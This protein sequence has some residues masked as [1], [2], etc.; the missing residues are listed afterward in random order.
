MSKELARTADLEAVIA[1]GDLNSLTSEQRIMLYQRTCETLG[2]N[3][4]TRPLEYLKL[5]GRTVIYI[6]KEACDQLR[7][8]HQITIQIIERVIENDVL[9]VVARATTPEGRSDEEIGSVSVAGLR[10]E[11]LANAQMKALTKAKRRA[12]LSICGLGHLDETEEPPVSPINVVEKRP[13]DHYYELVLRAESVGLHAHAAQLE[14]DATP[15]EI[16]AAYLGLNKVLRD[17]QRSEDGG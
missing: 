16:R 15:E 13:I 10:G 9:T 17:A 3:P 5:Q 2:L 4:L 8:I 12:T 7:K 11:A 1:N 14:D 6:R